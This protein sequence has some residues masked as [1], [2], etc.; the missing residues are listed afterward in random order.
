MKTLSPSTRSIAT[1]N[2][3]TNKVEFSQR[4]EIV[5]TVPA[6]V[7][8]KDDLYRVIDSVPAEKKHELVSRFNS[9]PKL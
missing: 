7:E 2:S 4:G 3:E 8:T 5:H 6:V 1:F 9:L